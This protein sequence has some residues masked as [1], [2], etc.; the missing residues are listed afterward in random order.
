MSL[1]SGEALRSVR[2]SHVSSDGRGVYSASKHGVVGTAVGLLFAALGIPGV[3]AGYGLLTKK[4]WA[5]VLTI[6]VGI[7]SLVN[8]PVGT[9]IGL[10]TLW[11]L[12]QPAATEYFVAP[13]PA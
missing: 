6:V 8:F 9:A 3:V 5:R 1:C 10:Y 11:V 2:A 12:T 13:T 4:P 7:L